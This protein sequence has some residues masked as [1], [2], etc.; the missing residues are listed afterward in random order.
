M[1]HFVLCRFCVVPYGLPGFRRQR[2]EPCNASDVLRVP[3]L[4]EATKGAGDSS[5]IST[6]CW[7]MWATG[8]S[9]DFYKATGGTRGLGKLT[10]NLPAGPP[11]EAP[12]RCVGVAL[13]PPSLQPT[14]LW[15]IQKGKADGVRC[16]D[17]S[18]PTERCCPAGPCARKPSN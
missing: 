18:E 14:A 15:G 7:A 4:L 16:E 3:W 5:P 11:L 8:G 9:P 10:L 6:A 2:Y 17:G 12:R 1:F 13:V